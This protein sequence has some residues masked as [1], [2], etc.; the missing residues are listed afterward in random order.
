MA[1]PQENAIGVTVELTVVDTAGTAVDI[2][3][4]TTKKLF[5]EKPNGDVVNKD[6][7][8]V[9]DGVNGKIK[10]VTVAGDLSPYGA[11]KCQAY[12]VKAG[13][14]NGRTKTQFFDVLPNVD[15]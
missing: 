5:F 14:V 12:I 11:W 4:A 2:S 6:A 15:S 1:A 8:Y 7:D 13:L 10:Y 9:T 3:G